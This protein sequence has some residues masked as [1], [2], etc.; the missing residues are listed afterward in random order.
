V[1]RGVQSLAA[2]AAQAATCF[3]RGAIKS[4]TIA[5]LVACIVL[6]CMHMCV[7]VRMGVWVCRCGRGNWHRMVAT[8]ACTKG[9]NASRQAIALPSDRA[10]RTPT[11]SRLR[12]LLAIDSACPVHTPAP[13]EPCEGQHILRTSHNQRGPALV[14]VSTVAHASPVTCPIEKGTVGPSKMCAFPLSLPRAPE[15]S[16][17]HTSLTQIRDKT[18]TVK[19]Q[20]LTSSKNR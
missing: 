7:H 9:T 16:P 11:R 20:C 2:R 8:C 12:L 15:P 13:G 17:A 18:N 14:L 19:P 3:L 6:D 10:D 4:T 1:W 5:G